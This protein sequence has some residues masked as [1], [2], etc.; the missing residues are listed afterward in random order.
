MVRDR[1]K[2][3]TSYVAKRYAKNALLFAGSASAVGAVMGG[4]KIGLALGAVVAGVILLLVSPVLIRSLF[5]DGKETLQTNKT[6]RKERER[7]EAHPVAGSVSI[8]DD[9]AEPGALS[10]TDSAG[11]GALSTPRRR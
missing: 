2:W 7:R 10:E 3:A 1:A 8:A 6:I 9:G 4:M 5:I 11:P